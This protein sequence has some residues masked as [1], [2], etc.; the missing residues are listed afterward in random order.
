[1]RERQE[2]Y[3][4]DPRRWVREHRDDFMRSVAMAQE[5]G[6]GRSTYSEDTGRTGG[7]A[8][9][10]GYAPEQH[11]YDSDQAGMVGELRALQ[12]TRGIW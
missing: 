10:G 2:F 8:S 7:I 5:L 9:G 12:K 11:P 4:E 3:N 1:M 6:H